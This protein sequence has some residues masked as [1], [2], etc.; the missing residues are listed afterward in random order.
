MTPFT[1]N[2]ILVYSLKLVLTFS[3][4]LP[5]LFPC[6][7]L[8][9]EINPC[10]L[11]RARLKNIRITLEPKNLYLSYFEFEVTSPAIVGLNV[12]LNSPHLPNEGSS[13]LLWKSLARWSN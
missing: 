8:K 7:K 13:G 2:D 10:C 11:I 5:N 12:F 3:Q 6:V 4:V 1:K 9:P